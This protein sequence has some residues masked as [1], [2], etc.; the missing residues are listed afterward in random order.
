MTRERTELRRASFLGWLPSTARAMLEAPRKAKAKT[1]LI[2]LAH[3]EE[4]VFDCLYHELPKR[5]A[6]SKVE[7]RIGRVVALRLCARTE[8]EA[9]RLRVAKKK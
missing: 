6:Y 9:G 2:S 1:V 7:Q 8:R 5:V 3:L 4:S